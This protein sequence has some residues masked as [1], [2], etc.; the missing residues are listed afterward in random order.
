MNIKGV[1]PDNYKPISTE[2]Q[3]N[4]VALT[5]LH[6]NPFN[7]R[8]AV[9]INS[10]SGLF[11]TNELHKRA[12]S[13]LN[14]LIEQSRIA[15]QEFYRV[16]FKGQANTIEEAQEIINENFGYFEI[17]KAINSKEFLENFD[18]NN[19]F[20]TEELAKKYLDK[21]IIMDYNK[22][23]IDYP[24]LKAHL[25]NEIERVLNKDKGKV[26]KKEINKFLK[27]KVQELEIK[28]IEKETDT[29]DILYKAMRDYFKSK[30][31][32]NSEF[33]KIL[34]SSFNKVSRYGKVK[35]VI[36][37]NSNIIGFIGEVS[38]DMFLRTLLQEFDNSEIKTRYIGETRKDTGKQS[39]VDFLIGKY[40]IQ[41]KN[42]LTD[43]STYSFKV[44][45]DL[46]IQTL[47]DQLQSYEDGDRLKYLL[48]NISY[49]QYFG[50]PNKLKMSDIKDGILIYVNNILSSYAD[51]LLTAESIE[52]NITSSYRNNFFF[53][54]N[55]YLI[56]MSIMLEG[57]RD[58]LESFKETGDLS[59]KEIGYINRNIGKTVKM[60]N[61]AS[62]I[63][64]KTFQEQK[65]EF[66]SDLPDDEYTYGG[67]LG[68]FGSIYGQNAAKGIKINIA[69][70]FVNKNLDK[71]SRILKV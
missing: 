50:R 12:I 60:K 17:F 71:L 51:F 45:K 19:R 29:N 55:K 66:L 65:R 1:K 15:E 26:S 46:S 63:N 9:A 54:K 33:Y 23:I 48:V 22:G 64:S 59:G 13:K 68:E 43:S 69:Y 27:K 18:N 24:S 58:S 52:P 41:V 7:F 57:I 62:N 14:S 11:K 56:P 40:G 70:N 4:L 28:D 30:G 10:G 2:T 20:K 53:Y 5:Y 21:D 67:K 32:K 36:N 8:N 44:K 38:A 6:S 61:I 25:T 3:K 37:N 39:P 42:T 47:I 31:I 34:K 49:L 16:A 35:L